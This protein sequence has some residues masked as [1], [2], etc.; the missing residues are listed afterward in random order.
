[1]RIFSAELRPSA[2]KRW[3]W[4]SPKRL[5]QRLKR[6]QLGQQDKAIGLAELADAIT[7]DRPQFPSHAF[8]LHLTELTLAIQAAGPDGVC[9]R[10]QSRF[11][12]V[13]LPDRTKAA[14]HDYKAYA[15]LGP[16]ER[17]LAGLLDRLH[18]H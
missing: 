13:E 2:R 5:I 17:L 11:E 1:M 16:M 14:A 15:Y 9:H 10:L 7:N 8:T 6:R 18:R 12:K 3:P 4:L